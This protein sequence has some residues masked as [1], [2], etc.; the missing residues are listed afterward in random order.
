MSSV[1]PAPASSVARLSRSGKIPASRCARFLRSRATFRAD[2][3]F[4]VLVFLPEGAIAAKTATQ[5]IPAMTVFLAVFTG[6]IVPEVQCFRSRSEVSASPQ[7]SDPMIDRSNSDVKCFGHHLCVPVV[8]VQ[9]QSEPSTWHQE[10]QGELK[11]WTRIGLA[12]FVAAGWLQQ[13]FAKCPRERHS[14]LFGRTS[15]T[16]AKFCM[17]IRRCDMHNHESITDIG[18]FCDLDIIDCPND[19]P[20]GHRGF[21]HH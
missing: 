17:T 6:L 4:A 11:S 21:R 3:S 20:G 1:A 15:R 10:L 7:I 16:T 5:A 14:R 13:H 12:R 8:V 2:R 9:I 18:V 19:F